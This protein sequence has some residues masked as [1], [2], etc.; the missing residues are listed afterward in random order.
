MSE[1]EKLG[2]AVAQWKSETGKNPRWQEAR[3]V[4]LVYEAIRNPWVNAQQEQPPI[5]ELVFTRCIGFGGDVFYHT[6][7]WLGAYLWERPAL[8]EPD[9]FTVTHWQYIQ[10]VEDQ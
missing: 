8:N 4:E 5:G 3:L 10:P 9:P 7:R 1:T 6:N 2:E